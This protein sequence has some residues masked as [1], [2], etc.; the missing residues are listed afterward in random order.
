MAEG[1]WTKK[2][3]QKGSLTVEIGSRK[4]SAL[5]HSS[6]LR[7][8]ESRSAGIPSRCSGGV[9]AGGQYTPM[10]PVRGACRFGDFSRLPNDA[11]KST[12]AIGPNQKSIPPAQQINAT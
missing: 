7:L 10:S 2:A 11:S 3:R 1:S 8:S 12:E 6:G 9:G 5:Q 4:N